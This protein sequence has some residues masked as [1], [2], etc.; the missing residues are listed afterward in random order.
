MARP[1]T[2]VTFAI[3]YYFGKLD[4]TG[5]HIFNLALHIANGVLLFFI[6]KITAGYLSY[7]DDKNTGLIALFSSLIFIVHPIQTE[8]VTYIATRSAL[9]LFLFAWDH[10]LHK[11]SWD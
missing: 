4:T 5:Y 9:Y 3:N 7:R 2:A 10:T 6:I 11:G 1:L 8:S